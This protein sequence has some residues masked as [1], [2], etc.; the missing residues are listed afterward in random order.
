MAE[1][2]VGWTNILNA[3]LAT[4]TPSQPASSQQLWQPTTNH[5]ASSMQH[6]PLIMVV[7]ILMKMAE[8]MG[9][10]GSGKSGGG[11]FWAQQQW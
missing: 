8:L 3:V 1:D 4:G 9:K 11:C 7:E 10:I 2:D 5:V 6:V